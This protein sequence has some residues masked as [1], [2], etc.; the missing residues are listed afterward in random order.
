MKTVL[1]TGASTG[2]GEDAALT[3]AR[4]GYRVIAGVRRTE[5]GEALKVKSKENLEYQILDV[6]NPDQIVNIAEYLKKNGGLDVLINN[7][8]IAVAGPLEFISMD[9]MR[10]QFEVNVFGLLAVTQACLGMLRESKGRVVNVGSISGK[11]ASPFVGPYAASKFAVEAMSD[12]LRMELQEWGIQVSLIEPGPI[13]TPI[14][15]KSKANS[16]ADFQKLGPIAL[17]LYG[18]RL[19]S[20]IKMAEKLSKISIPV[21]NV[22]RAILHA[23][24]SSSPK[25]RY[26]VGTNARIQG[27]LARFIPDR[28]RDKMILSQLK[29]RG[30]VK[31]S[32]TKT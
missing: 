23:V 27:V 30:P 7:A 13:K 9:Q 14:W 24:M 18:S 19:K 4:E 20:M 32:L 12:S 29:T 26:V 25:T 15:E 1:V 22:S 11:L 16:E 3:L 21:E 10:K 6:T 5:D 31:E 17:E 2:I 28:L 8:G